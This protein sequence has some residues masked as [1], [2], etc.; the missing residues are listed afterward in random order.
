MG[1]E[2]AG[3]RARPASA[4]LRSSW[5]FCTLIAEVGASRAAVVAYLAPGFAVAYGALF[6]GEPITG[7]AIGGLVLILAG[8]WLAAEGRAPGSAGPPRR[9]RPLSVPDRRYLLWMSPRAIFYG[10]AVV[11]SIGLIFGLEALDLSRNEYRG[12]LTGTL[13]VLGFSN[14]ER[15]LRWWGERRRRPDLDEAPSARRSDGS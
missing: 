15:F 8:S 10:V 13:I 2:C 6:L 3:V 9:S 1:G 14:E 7:G 5:F 11:L 12:L 4:P